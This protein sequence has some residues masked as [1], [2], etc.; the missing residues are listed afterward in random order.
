MN[1]SLIKEVLKVAKRLDAR[2]LVNAYEGNISAKEDGFI[3]ITPTL[4]NK[5]FLEE[6]DIVVIDPDGK[7][8]SGKKGPSSELKMHR[9]VY[10]MRDNIGG[11]IHTHA[12]FLAAF[13]ICN[14]AV[15]SDA[16]AELLCDHKTIEVVPYGRLGTDDIYNGVEPVFK[17][18]LDAVLLGNHGV[19]T[20]G[21]TVEDALNRME[22]IE[23]AAK[24]LVLSK[25]VGENFDLDQE[26]IQAL[27][28]M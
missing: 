26:E 28:A 24:I 2:Q 18:G 27:L 14:M 13:A 11:V 6:E 20:V 17:K 5:A 22:S 9:A 12:P 7:Q 3:Y 16:H 10:D 1:V 15:E 4:S 23:S 25:L 21:E 19:L 8:V